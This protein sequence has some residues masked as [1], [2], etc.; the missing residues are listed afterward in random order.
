MATTRLPISWRKR[1]RQLTR[2][3]S[4]MCFKSWMRTP[5]RNMIPR[6]SSKS[7]VTT[8]TSNDCLSVSLLLFGKHRGELLTSADKKGGASRYALVCLVGKLNPKSG[9]PE[10][11][12]MAKMRNEAEVSTLVE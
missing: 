12:P 4:R 2:R 8:P 10:E 3:L 9:K 7:L 5:V 11:P 6:R 1:Q